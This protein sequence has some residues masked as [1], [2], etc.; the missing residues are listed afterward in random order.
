MIDRLCGFDILE[1]SVMN[2]AFPA[3]V[4]HDFPVNIL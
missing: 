2:L 4:G 3:A 1:S